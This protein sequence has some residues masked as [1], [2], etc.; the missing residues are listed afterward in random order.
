MAEDIEEPRDIVS[1][2]G[3]VRNVFSGQLEISVRAA[4]GCTACAIRDNCREAAAVRVIRVPCENSSTYKI[5]DRVEITSRVSHGL[6]A[7]LLLFFV[8]VVLL[9][10]S[11]FAVLG[12]G[13][14][15]AE[16]AVAGLAAVAVWALVLRLV[17]PRIQSAMPVKVALAEA[18]RP[19]SAGAANLAGNSG[20]ASAGEPASHRAVDASADVVSAE[21]ACDADATRQGSDG[22][23]FPGKRRDK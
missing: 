14:S 2:S 22:R 1:Q 7:V 11:V 13:A 12:A 21:L 19:M 9:L 5:G 15:E 10:A 17:N 16:A 23:L 6:V 4:S 18:G 3:L 20:T 8:P